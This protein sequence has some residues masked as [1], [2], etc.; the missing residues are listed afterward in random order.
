ML[1]CKLQVI[2]RVERAKV[3]HWTIIP[4]RVAVVLLDAVAVEQL[5]VGVHVHLAKGPL[6]LASSR[7]Q[8]HV[9]PQPL[10][11]ELFC[12][13]LC[14]AQ[15]RV[16]AELRLQVRAI[17]ELS[18]LLKSERVVEVALVVPRLE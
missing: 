5:R 10:V 4:R 17:H 1:V 8:A 11:A 14:L 2:N 13:L 9:R 6:H 15:R 18:K 7:V 16:H 12:N 3:D